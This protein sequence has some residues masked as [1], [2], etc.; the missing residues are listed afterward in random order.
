MVNTVAPFF[1]FLLG[2][3]QAIPSPVYAFF[4]WTISLFAILFAYSVIKEWLS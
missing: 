2:V 1:N 3:F 4:K